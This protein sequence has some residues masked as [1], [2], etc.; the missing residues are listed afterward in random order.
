MVPVA[1][2]FTPPVAYEVKADTAVDTTIGEAFDISVGNPT[3]SA[4]YEII[5]RVDCTEFRNATEVDGD[6][7]RTDIMLSIDDT[8]D[9]TIVIKN[10]SGDVIERVNVHVAKADGPGDE[11]QEGDDQN[12]DDTS[13]EGDETGEDD[14]PVEGADIEEEKRVELIILDPV[15]GII[16]TTYGPNNVL[17]PVGDTVQLNPVPDQGW[18]FKGWSFRNKSGEDITDQ[19]DIDE[20]GIFAM[21]DY[22]ISVTAEFSYTTIDT[23]EVVDA[24]TA[25]NVGDKIVFTGNLADRT[26]PRYF[27]LAEVWE[28]SDGSGITNSEKINENLE[29][30][31]FK[32]DDEVHDNARYSYSLIFMTNDGYTFSE[33]VKLLFNGQEIEPDEGGNAF[34]E[35]GEGVLSFSDILSFGEAP[36]EDMNK[37]HKEDVED[38]TGDEGKTVEKTVTTYDYET[39]SYTTYEYV[40][41]VRPATTTRKVYRYVTTKAPATGDVN[42]TAVWIALGIAGASGLISGIAVAKRRKRDK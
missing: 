32:I 34:G 42:H 12:A 38:T 4:S 26:D 35:G 20:F 3:D 39:V 18:S 30:K 2:A 13:G 6:T 17:V 5:P 19:I 1:V 22:S 8:G 16:G 27:I 29:G 36:E 21:P 14:V 33:D 37:H 7:Y 31:G 25:F 9:Y 23:V 28:S 41:V 10:G 15:G 24:T 11:G 40:T